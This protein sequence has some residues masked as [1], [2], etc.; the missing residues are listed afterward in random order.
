MPV[1]EVCHSGLDPESNPSKAENLLAPGL[2]IDMAK[3]GSDTA[4][5]PLL[6]YEEKL[7]TLGFYGSGDFFMLKG[8][9]TEL[10]AALSI[11]RPNKYVPGNRP[12]LHP[13]RQA[14]LIIGD[15]T[16]GYLGEVHPAVSDAYGISERVYIAVV[17]LNELSK[18]SDFTVKYKEVPKYP[19]VPRDLSLVLSKEIPA[20]D[21]EEKIRRGGG[22][23]LESVTLFD[24]YEGAQIKDGSKSLSYALVF[25]APDRTLEDKEVNAQL[26]KIQ[27]ALE[28]IGAKLRS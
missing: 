5:R 23:L 4:H 7:L 19:S 2:D 1:T 21:I 6:P 18:L 14:E 27:S 12:Y 15:I 25:R 20:G 11:K 26:E 13:G 24:V 22:K 3:L 17:S 10:L 9:V 28:E 8:A 16:A